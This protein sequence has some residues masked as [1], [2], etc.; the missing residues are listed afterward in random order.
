M[1]S[2]QLKF[3]RFITMKP[4]DAPLC[5]SCLFDY[6]DV[7]TIDMYGM[8][9][10]EERFCGNSIPDDIVSV[11]QRVEIVFKSDYTGGKQMGFLG[12]YEFIQ[13]SKRTSRRQSNLKYRNGLI[14]FVLLCKLMRIFSFRL[15]E[16]RMKNTLVHRDDLC[17]QSL[18]S[19]TSTRNL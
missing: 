2:Q 4:C 1:T 15:S 3:F 8:K 14:T 13:E 11:H 7:F 12:R 10:L 18:C 17:A 9:H 5:F 16:K 6:V 19:P